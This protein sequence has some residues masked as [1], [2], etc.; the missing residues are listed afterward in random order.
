MTPNALVPSD[1]T[2]LC[3]I[4]G[5]AKGDHEARTLYCPKR[6]TFAAAD[7]GAP[8]RE[9]DG[10]ERPT[11]GPGSPLPK[12]PT[13]DEVKAGYALP[14][15]S[16]DIED[17]FLGPRSERQSVDGPERPAARL[18]TEA[19][20]M[21]EFERRQATYEA[22]LDR[23][24]RG[25]RSV[26]PPRPV[27]PHTPGFLPPSQPVVERPQDEPPRCDHWHLSRADWE[28]DPLEDWVCDKCGKFLTLSRASAAAPSALV[29]HVYRNG[30]RCVYLDSEGGHPLLEVEAVVSPGGDWDEAQV[31][32]EEVPPQPPN[33]DGLW[34]M[35]WPW[36]EAN[37]R[38]DDASPDDETEYDDEEYCCF[39]IDKPQWT[40][41]V[42]SLTSAADAD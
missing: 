25:E 14:Y 34:E 15:G 38:P 41:L 40:L 31:L 13:P 3:A 33:E 11:R 26:P 8:P 35:R 32:H 24:R 7:A 4:C 28:G 16:Q 37:H 9:P 21:A 18:P 23:F 5:E 27:K 42:P 20:Q 29:A 17:M 39:Y 12:H 30:P 1:L 22:E 19:E 10:T 2:V 36:R 6:T